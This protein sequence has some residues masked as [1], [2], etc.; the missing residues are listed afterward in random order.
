MRQLALHYDKA[1]LT[2]KERDNAKEN[3]VSNIKGKLLTSEAAGEKLLEELQ[4]AKGRAKPQQRQ[5]QAQYD[6]LGLTV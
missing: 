6:T 3:N 4:A 2:L 1:L 5:Y